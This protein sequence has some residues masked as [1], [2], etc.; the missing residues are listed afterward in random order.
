M[1]LTLHDQGALHNKKNIHLCSQLAAIND[2]GQSKWSDAVSYKT[3]P[4]R[5]AAPPKPQIKGKI[6]AH[7]F[8]VVW[9]KYTVCIDY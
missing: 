5:P 8:K 1:L 7:S 9:G 2:E 4:D 6:H 3:L